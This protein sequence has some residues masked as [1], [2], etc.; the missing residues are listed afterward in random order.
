M[1]LYRGIV[2]YI[3]HAA[4]TFQYD[5]IACCRAVRFVLDVCGAAGARGSEGAVL[6]QLSEKGVSCRQVGHYRISLSNCGYQLIRCK[7]GHVWLLILVI[8]CTWCECKQNAKYKISWPGCYV[9]Q[10]NLPWLTWIWFSHK[11]FLILGM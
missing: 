10:I 9:I 11:K 3:C 8:D 4:G 6:E 5:M 7:I 1:L 2:F